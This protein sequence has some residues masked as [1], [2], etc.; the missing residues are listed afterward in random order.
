[1]EASPGAL[2][3]DED[4]P[5][6]APAQPV[7]GRDGASQSGVVMGTPAYMP[8]E[9]AQGKAG[10]I[11]PRADVF[12]LGAILCEVLTGRPP[13]GAGA[14]DEVCR[15]AAE[16]DLTDAHARLDACEADEALRDLARRCLAVD[17]LARP[18]DAGDVARDLAAYLAASQER[19]RQAQV[20]RAAAEAR[21]KR[22]GP[23]RRPNG[24][25]GG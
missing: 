13:Y 3:P 18:P 5:G 21:R 17:R 8:P 9:Q 19:L 20:E 7:S 11:D 2:S 6:P 10:L 15:Q 22:S 23:R 12:A 1:M 24:T 4:A 16:G 25:R 14:I